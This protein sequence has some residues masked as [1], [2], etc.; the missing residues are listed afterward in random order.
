MLDKLGLT[1]K[2]DGEGY[3]LRADATGRLRLSLTTYLG[4]LPFTSHGRSAALES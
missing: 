2:K 1:N 3:R 4:F